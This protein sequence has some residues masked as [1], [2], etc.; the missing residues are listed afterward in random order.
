[1]LAG[2]FEEGKTIL[3]K[4]IAPPT[5]AAQ[6]AK[7][8]SFIGPLTNLKVYHDET[9]KFCLA[10]FDEE[11]RVGPALKL[12]GKDLMGDSL[13]I[14][15]ATAES[16]PA[17][18]PGVA[19]ETC[20]TDTMQNGPGSPVEQV[21]GFPPPLLPGALRPPSRFPPLTPQ[22][23]DEVSRTVYV[24]NVNSEVTPEL[25]QST[26][27]VCGKITYSRLAGD[28]TH[29][30]RF[31]FIEFATKE[32]AQSAL[33]MNGQ[34]LIDRPLKVNN[35]KNPIVKT[36]TTT[37]RE[38]EAIQRRLRRAAERIE[39]RVK[40]RERSRRDRSSSPE[41]RT[42]R[43]RHSRRGDHSRN[44]GSSHRSSRRH[45]RSSSRDHKRDRSSRSK[46]SSS[47]S[48]HKR[49]SHRRSKSRSPSSHRSRTDSKKR[50]RSSSL[51]PEK[52]PKKYKASDDREGSKK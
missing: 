1:M 5:T 38:E 10:Q 51:S 36:P 26:F 27:E 31:A 41:R 40:D 24:G 19:V 23:S 20:D 6:L 52:E 48:K 32:A 33:K 35:S 21:T 11:D 28:G 18:S 29:P 43:D 30:S 50:S 3:V 12:H 45:E 34:L 44:G 25:L 37:P 8:F 4:N 17:T 47:S 9:I 15:L 14:S 2:E 42:S 46:H 39:Q 7:F 49:S 16:I 22:Q 13:D